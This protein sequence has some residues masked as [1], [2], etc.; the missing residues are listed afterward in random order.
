MRPVVL[1]L[2]IVMVALA[3]A[4]GRG[5]VDCSRRWVTLDLTLADSL[6]RRSRVA[7]RDQEVALRRDPRGRR[8]APHPR[9]RRR[10]PGH[11]GQR[12]RETEL[13]LHGV[14]A[15]SSRS[16]STPPTTA[17][18]RVGIFTVHERWS[19][20][21]AA[22]WLVGIGSSRPAGRSAHAIGGT[23]QLPVPLWLYL[24][25]AA[26]AVAASFV[27][28]GLLVARRGAP[29]RYR[30]VRPSRSASGPARPARPRACVVVRRDRRR[31]RRRRHHP[32]A[33]G[34]AVDRHLGRPAD[35]RGPRREPVAVA[36]PVP[37]DLRRARL[38][39]APARPRAARR[40]PRL[41]RRAGALAGG[42]AAGAGVWSELILP[43]GSVAATV[44]ALMVGYTCSPWSG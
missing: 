38:A 12:R 27:V 35:R 23:F 25:G 13:D 44:A 34:A 9:L 28:T 6:V 37:H 30:R 31:V 17:R 14:A 26:V 1:L 42:G 22:R 21:L 39:R 3:G 7:C 18:R 16:S 29:P 43:G 10:G 20:R 24:A 2:I 36:Q 40:R 11:R 5:P 32:A 41:P 19:A 15:A 8:R 33:G 4:A